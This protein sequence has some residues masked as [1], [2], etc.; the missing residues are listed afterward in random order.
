MCWD[1]NKSRKN[2]SRYKN[3]HGILQEGLVPAARIQPSL[4]QSITQRGFSIKGHFQSAMR[5]QLSPGGSE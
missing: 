2:K 4:I 3:A 1:L 5:F